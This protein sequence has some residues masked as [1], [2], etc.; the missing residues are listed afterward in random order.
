MLYMILTFD[1]PIYG[2]V[3]H[4]LFPLI[5]TEHQIN[6]G[7]WSVVLILRLSVYLLRPRDS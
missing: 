1:I 4:L 3:C 5:D 7:R 2:L 6:A